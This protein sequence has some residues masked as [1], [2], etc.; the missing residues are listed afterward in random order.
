MMLMGVYPTNCSAVVTAA[1]QGRLFT[2]RNQSRLNSY[3]SSFT[4]NQIARMQ[5]AL[6]K[7]QGKPS[8][9]ACVN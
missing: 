9:Y 7:P 5:N 2:H 3:V 4:T 1:V 8:E 6:A